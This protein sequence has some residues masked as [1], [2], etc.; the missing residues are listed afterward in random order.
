MQICLLVDCCWL[1]AVDPKRNDKKELRPCEMCTTKWTNKHTATHPLTH[2]QKH[3]HMHKH[4]RTNAHK[5]T[6]K[7]TATHSLTHTC[8][9]TNTQQEHKMGRS[10][11]NFNANATP[12][13]YQ[14]KC[15]VNNSVC[16]LKAHKHKERTQNTAT[17]DARYCLRY[18]H[19]TSNLECKF[20]TKIKNLAVV[21]LPK[22]RPV[23]Q[24]RDGAPPGMTATPLL[25][26]L[27]PAGFNLQGAEAATIK[28]YPTAGMK[29]TRRVM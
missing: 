2:S 17:Y 9:H 1:A 24:K 26:N 7:H 19:D 10:W 6:K 11:Q 14:P 8:T 5:Q 20:D 15:N 22:K 29:Q 21:L 16:T 18:T 12:Q 4:I 23:A 25:C 28:S 27:I 3:A 13:Q